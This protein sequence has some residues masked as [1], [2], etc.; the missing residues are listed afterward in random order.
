MTELT[1]SEYYQ[2]IIKHVTII[3][4]R[5]AEKDTMR[6]RYRAQTA[7]R[8][9]NLGPRGLGRMAISFQGAGEHW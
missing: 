6:K 5:Y 4:P 1:P 8:Q 3:W 2:N 7:T 9:Q